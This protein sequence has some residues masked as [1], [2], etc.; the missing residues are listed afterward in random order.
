MV[1]ESGTS[2]PEEKERAARELIALFQQTV[3]KLASFED[4]EDEQAVA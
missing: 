2:S 1:I 3:L 4:P